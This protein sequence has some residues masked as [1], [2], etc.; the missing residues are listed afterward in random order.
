EGVTLDDR[1]RDA[2]ESDIY[3][4]AGDPEDLWRDFVFASG[5][6][7]PGEGMDVRVPG[8][9]PNTV[10]QVQIWSRD[11]GSTPTRSAYW[12]RTTISFDGRDG[13]PPTSLNDSGTGVVN[14]LTDASGTLLLEGR[15]DRSLGAASHNVFLN[16][17]EVLSSVDTLALE[18]NTTTGDVRIVNH[19]AAALSLNFYEIGS[20]SGALNLGGWDPLDAT[21]ATVETAGWQA[22]P[23]SSANLL[24]ETNLLAESTIAAGSQLGL[25]SAFNVGGAQDLKFW[26][27]DASGN[28]APAPVSYVTGGFAADFDG[29]GDVDGAD[30]AGS[31]QSWATRFGSDLDGSDFLSWQREFGA[32]GTGN[33]ASSSVPEPHAVLAA[34]VLAMLTTL[35]RRLS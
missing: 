17:F 23:S 12:N 28:V 29:D 19:G 3:T 35:R 25:A 6:D 14:A 34:G 27:A 32:G 10:Y 22:A 21:P 26:Y 13:S 7:Q 16:G 4:N 5:S 30:L 20:E 33:A 24:V 9:T 18:V 15:A 1:F 8:F 31:A 2:A 11:P